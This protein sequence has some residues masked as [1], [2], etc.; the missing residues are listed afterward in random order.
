MQL[1]ELNEK[2]EINI[3]NLK[4]VHPL[5]S[6]GTVRIKDWVKYSKLGSS[7]V[8]IEKLDDVSYKV[9]FIDKKTKDNILALKKELLDNK[10]TE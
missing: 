6:N 2:L 8:Y 3:D 5:Y 1:K 10:T 7:L 4:N 9:S